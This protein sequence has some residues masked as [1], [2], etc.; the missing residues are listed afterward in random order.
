MDNKKFIYIFIL[1]AILIL[2]LFISQNVYAKEYEISNYDINIEVT[3]NGDYLITE[4]ITYNFLEGKFSNAYREISNSGLKNLEF[5]SLDG[6]FTSIKNKRVE[7][8]GNSLKVN[9]SYPETDKN[10]EFIL[11][12][13]SN[14]VL[15]SKEN[16]NIIDF[17]VIEGGWEVPLKNIDINI[18]FPQRVSGILVAPKKDIET[19]DGSAV[20]LHIDSLSAN[21]SY[22]ISIKFDKIIDTNYPE[23][24]SPYFWPLII[25][26]I[27][28]IA[29]IIFTIVKEYQ[30]KPV[31]KRSD[32][33]LSKLN[34]LEMANL[35]YPKSGEKRK[36]IISEIF[37]LAQRGKIKLISKL[38][39]G[40]FGSKKAEI[41]V[42][43]LSE[44]GLNEL[45]QEIINSLKEED[46]LKEFLQKPKASK[47]AMDMTR[48][49]LKDLGLFNNKAGQTRI[50]DIYLG[51]LTSILGIAGIILAPFSGYPSISGI[52]LFLILLGIGRFIKSALVPMLSPTGLDSQK[53]IEKLLD[54]KKEKFEKVLNENSN[55]A[56]EL[57]FVEMSYIILHQKFKQGKFKKYKKKLKKADK[58]EKP[59]WI[60]F[61]MTELDE[62][63][64]ALEV[65]EVI[66]YVLLSTIFIVNSTTGATGASGAGGGS[67]GGGG[68]S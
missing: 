11:K 50:T 55:R 45:E 16:K 3:K 58:F 27:L 24:K 46:N 17:K 4:K 48:Q 6:V 57:F 37:S 60:E 23:E 26:T 31:S 38:D 32:I 5:I 44:E 1:L 59:E 52:G 15:S 10:A 14:K 41:K 42:D 54:E 8:N 47:K 68:A 63:L 30:N 18:D 39:S 34:Y 9:W 29:V 22:N 53:R 64:D 28:G 2:P 40:F 20:K 35:C 43:I 67:A 13:R 25:G 33:E 56:I 7:E 21:E 65:V 19:Q 12:Y 61:D 49:N 62:T 66:D 36:G 51:V